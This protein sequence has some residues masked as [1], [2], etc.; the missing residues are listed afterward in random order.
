[1]GI[2]FLTALLGAPIDFNTGDFDGGWTRYES[3]KYGFSMWAPLRARV[4]AW[5][6]QSDWAGMEAVLEPVR[7]RGVLKNRIRESETALASTIVRMTGTY[8]E[9]WKPVGQGRGQQGFDWFRVAKWEG[10]S[11]V[12]FAIYGVGK[13]GSYALLLRTTKAHFNAYRE[14]YQ[15]W[16]A[17][18]QVF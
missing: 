1:M 5:E 10:P 17:G 8:K 18:V 12:I 7:L 6:Q 3:K 11:Q 9:G 14:D 15:D 16:W 4:S 13:R 2:V